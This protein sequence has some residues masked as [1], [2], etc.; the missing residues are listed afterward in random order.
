MGDNMGQRRGWG[1]RIRLIGLIAVIGAAFLTTGCGGN[2]TSRIRGLYDHEADKLIAFQRAKKQRSAEDK[3]KAIDP[4]RL[5]NHADQLALQGEWVAAAFQYNR[6]MLKADPQAKIRL[7]AKSGLLYLKFH[8]WTQAETMLVQSVRERPASA[9]L[10]Q[11]LGLARLAQREFDGAEQA[12]QKAIE[13]DKRRWKAFNGLG[14][15]ANYRK[16]PAKAVAYFKQAVEL[17]PDRAALHNNLGL[18]LMLSGHP[19]EAERAYRQA[20]L[21]EPKNQVAANNLGLLLAKQN[22]TRD[23]YR[24]FEKAV[25]P[26]RAHNNV[27]VVLAWEGRKKEAASQFRRA[28]KTMP[29]YY[30]LA[31]RHLAEVDPGD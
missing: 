4:V 21:L 29:R 3:V 13:L 18:A 19:A 9:E 17:K 22:K 15:A 5:E 20:L 12:L 28:V 1:R 24:A 7:R 10:W 8:Q 16:H 31:Q 14:M 27:G 2:K 25:G 30:E 11:G 6:A 23:A 26:A